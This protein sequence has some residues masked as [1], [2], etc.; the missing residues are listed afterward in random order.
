MFKYTHSEGASEDKVELH[1]PDC[2][3]SHTYNTT[4][5]AAGGGGVF[6]G[7]L[8]IFTV[9]ASP[10]PLLFISLAALVAGGYLLYNEYQLKSKL[11]ATEIGSGS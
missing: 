3:A 10:W 4:K 6:I 1:C 2:A 11:D 7:L 5:L 8:L 9:G